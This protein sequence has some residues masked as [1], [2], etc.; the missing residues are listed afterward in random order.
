MSFDFSGITSTLGIVS[1][2]ENEDSTKQFG[3]FG[4]TALTSYLN[5]NDF[6]ALT[7]QLERFTLKNFLN[8]SALPHLYKSGAKIKGYLVDAEDASNRRKFQFNP[9]SMEYSRAANY[10]QIK[11]PGMQYPLIY[12]IN[13]DVS[14]FELELFVVDRP[15]TGK[16]NDDINWC[17]SFLP[18]YRND[19]FFHRPHPLIYAYGGFVCKCVLTSFT[20]HID[21]YDTNGEP[22]MAHLKLKLLIVDIPEVSK[23]VDI[24]GGLGGVIIH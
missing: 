14:E 12:F 23:S 5:L 8:G 1:E 21:E 20:S 11:S 6:R 2:G 4:K 16:I 13:G 10:G 22:Y 19:N 3:S 17:N 18:D 7:N 15:A 9:Q 24:L